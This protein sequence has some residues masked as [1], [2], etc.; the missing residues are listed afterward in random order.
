MTKYNSPNYLIKYGYTNLKSFTINLD[1]YKSNY[2]KQAIQLLKLGL[3][4]ERFS[5]VNALKDE[6]FKSS[7]KKYVSNFA[8]NYTPKS[9]IGCALSHIM[10]CKY[11]HKNYIKKQKTHKQ[12]QQRN[13]TYFLIMEDDVFPL[14]DKDE[15]YEKLN[16]TLYDIQILDSNWEIIQLHSD[17]IMPTI[18]T[19]S[20]HIGSISA[21]A[22][23]I[24]K[25]AIKK[26]LKSKIYSHIDLIH[27]NFI[28]YNKYRAKENLFYSDEKTSL[29]RIVSYR[30]SSYSLLLKSKLFEFIN[31]YTNI[32][33]LRGEKKFLH[34][35]EYKVFK[36]PFFNKE[37]N[38]NDII[39]YFIGLKILSKLYYYKN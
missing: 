14:Y 26:T 19:Y 12:Q 30:L 37:F 32:I 3:A 35:F 20:T 7:Y 22:Y 1:D 31:Y 5:G 36:E 25:K 18:E 33:Q 16:K 39:D 9:V 15:F 23:L 6:H 13:P 21:A 28:N 38:T 27:H 10:C 8:L 24:S 4:S 29:N 2:E 17:G 34:Y 11:I